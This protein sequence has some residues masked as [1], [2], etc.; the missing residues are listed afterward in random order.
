MPGS[1]RSLQI[2]DAYRARLNA[3]SDRLGA[4]TEH[5]WQTV[6]VQDLDRSHAHWLMITIG[7][8]DPA[9]RAG[10]HLTAAYVAGFVGS[11]LGQRAT[12]IP[13]VD[14][15][16]YAGVAQDGRPLLEA[17][18]PTVI[19]VKK[20]LKDGKPPA[21]ALAEGQA[22]AVRLAA[23]A[24]TAAPRAA[25]HDQ[26]Q[27]HSMI[28]GWRRVTSGGCGACLAAA[29]HPYGHEPMRVH[30]HCHCTAEPIVRDVPDHAPRATGPEVFHRMTVEQ[31]DAALGPAAAQ[32]VRQGLVAWPDL[33]AVSPMVIGPDLITQAPVEALAA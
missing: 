33:I 32:L 9:Q 5:Y 18:A 8:L 12:E 11:E 6:T 16:Q 20:A 24:V 19:T 7:M 4:L 26:I 27:T 2:T 10:V 14:D 29:A 31:Q 25:L 28:T 3:L 22:R 13:H 30:D 15:A 21:D 23:S 17:L 1:P